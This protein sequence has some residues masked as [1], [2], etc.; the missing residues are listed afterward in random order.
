MPAQHSRISC[1]TV[2]PG[3]CSSR[4]LWFSKA[5]GWHDL[6]ASFW[7]LLIAIP[8]ILGASALLLKKQET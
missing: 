5:L 3:H 1:S 7:P 8:V 4:W 6:Q 2:L